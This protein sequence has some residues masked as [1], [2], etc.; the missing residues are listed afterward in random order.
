MLE[1]EKEKERRDLEKSGRLPG[2]GWTL[3]LGRFGE[4]GAGQGGM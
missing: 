3:V 2:R 4:G 1:S